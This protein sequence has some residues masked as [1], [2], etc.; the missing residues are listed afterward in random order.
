MFSYGNF[1]IIKLNER[2]KHRFKIRGLKQL[3]A[4]EKGTM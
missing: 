3:W 2:I 1:F 4:Q